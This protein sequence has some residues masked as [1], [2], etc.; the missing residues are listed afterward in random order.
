LILLTGALILRAPHS[1]PIRAEP[2]KPREIAQALENEYKGKPAITRIFAA[3]DLLEFD[4][5]GNLKG[6]PQLGAW[7]LYS[8]VEVE[9]IELKPKFL[10]I[11]AQRL[12][13]K[14]DS[15]KALFE[16]YPGGPLMIRI[17]LDHK[18]SGAEEIRPILAKLFLG[19]G[20]DFCA[21]V[22][23]Y[24]KSFCTHRKEPDWG[25]GVLAEMN[26]VRAHLG[27]NTTG[28][29]PIHTS[30]P[31]YTVPARDARIQGTVDTLVLVNVQGEVESVSVVRPLGMGLDDEAVKVIKT[32]KFKPATCDGVPIPQKVGVVTRFRIF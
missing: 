2:T 14:Y 15:A 12:F 21:L 31:K 30:E 17:A 9:T 3:A 23:A 16:P 27:N 4:S 32:W 6:T 18:P 8:H 19:Q 7:T 10:E 22:P 29:V 11:T 24:W 5:S 20:E 1:S 26:K 13:Q 25:S 28:A